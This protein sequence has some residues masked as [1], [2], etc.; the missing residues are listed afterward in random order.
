MNMKS[1]ALPCK[2]GLAL[3]AALALGTMIAL[4]QP[5]AGLSPE[6]M[7][8][9][10]ILVGVIVLLATKALANFVV[11]LLM[12]VLFVL[13]GCVDMATAFG[14]F[15]GTTFWLVVGILGIGAGI[16]AS[17]LLR[18]LAYHALL[19]FPSSFRGVVAALLGVGMVFQP[20]MPCTMAKQSIVAPVVVTLG[21]TLG[22]PRR[23]RQMAGLFNAMHIGWSVLGNLFISASYL[24]Y[25]FLGSLPQEVQAQFTWGRW[26]LSMLPWALVVLVGSYWVLT[27]L[28]R[29]QAG[30]ADIR[31]YIRQQLAQLGPVSGREKLVIALLLTA[32]VL[33]VTETATGIPA[34]MTALLCLIAMAACGLFTHTDFNTRMDW[35]MIVFIGGVLNAPTVMDALGISRWIG[36]VIAPVVS[37]LSGNI[38]LFITA[39]VLC[40]YLLRFAT[41][42][43]SLPVLVLIAV[44]CPLAG[45]LGINP[46]VIMIVAYC[47]APVWL[48]QYQSINMAAGWAAFGGERS[49]RFSDVRPGAAAYLVINLVALLV[50]VPY[51]TLLGYIA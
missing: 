7:R 15:S 30:Q 38:Y 22:F 5:P 9:M 13:L 36:S 39:L 40:T 4:A 23:S 11:A 44:L 27:R 10:G 2:K 18:R 26:F 35:D 51:W 8:A 43:Y 31:G 16:E 21:E 42:S 49:A 48:T 33:W 34:Y 17:G 28:Y 12:C 50:S 47:S 37:A 41:F 19:L 46:W 25:L 24:G 1:M 45:E 14:G 3:L 32:I 20:L 6:A 29:P